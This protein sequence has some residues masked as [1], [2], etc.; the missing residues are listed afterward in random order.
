MIAEDPVL[1]DYETKAFGTGTVRV[2]PT[3]IPALKLKYA[4][5]SV[6]RVRGR[7]L[8]LACGGGGMTKAIAMYRPD[9]EIVGCDLSMR[10]LAIAQENGQ[11]P[12]FSAGNVFQ[13]PFPRNS[14]DA[15]VMF[16]FL[17][18]LS[19]PA[20]ALKEVHRVL[21]PQGIFHTAVP[22]EGEPSTLH[23]MLW[24]LGWKAKEIHCGHVQMYEH[25][26]PEAIIE[27]AGFRIVDTEWTAHWI[28]QLADVCYF[29]WLYLRGK[30]VPY[31]IEGYLEVAKPSLKSRAV[32][33]AKA[34]VATLSYLESS[35]LHWFP[36][37]FGH[38]TCLG[39]ENGN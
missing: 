24:R 6:E 38:I 20:N 5:Q 15:V 39:N 1:F 29:S 33:L 30:G 3:Y 23:G 22:F 27:E 19:Y 10:S 2:S 32:F 34:L 36:A 16:D 11:G 26:Q 7:V 4:L 13:L 37:G 31:S 12:R 21:K 35:V 8:D 9:L 17:E 28:Y 18:H 14:F 25:G